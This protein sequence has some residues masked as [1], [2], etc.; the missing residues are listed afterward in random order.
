MKHYLVIFIFL[1]SQFT[2][3]KCPDNVQVIKKGEVANCDGLLFSPEASKKVDD[4]QSDV[5]YL[6]KITA[7]LL[8]RRD[9]SIKEVETLD[10]RLHLYIEQSEILAKQL[11]RKEKE[12]K[13]QKMIYFG[14]GILATGI[15][16]HGASQLTR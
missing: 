11:H 3:A 9:L 4:T 16:V 13:W 2:Y 15:A 10:K 7:H 1:F 6:E 12:D 5:V 14:L 8:K